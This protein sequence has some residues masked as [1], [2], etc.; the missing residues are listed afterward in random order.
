MKTK[1]SII[2]LTLI[3]FGQVNAQQIIKTESPQ[4]TVAAIS[5]LPA[6]PDASK[7]T[8]TK[9]TSPP[10][11]NKQTNTY[12]RPDANQRFKRYVKHMFGPVS[13][14][15]KVLSAG[16]STATN[17][18]EEWGGTWEGF[19]KRFASSVGRGIIRE[20][21]IYTLGEAFKLDSNFYRS[22]KRDFKSKVSNAVLSTF[23][24]R[25]PDGTRVFGFPHLVGVYASSIIAYETWYPDRYTYKSGLRSGTISLGINVAV[26]LFK[27]FIKK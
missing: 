18:P 3:I 5:D 27:E 17:S 12:V 11:N 19:G 7:E 1:L 4:P 15:T 8:Q 23:T 6:E 26:N 9:P 14:G 16:Y 2:V 10:T 22:Q 25:K 21:T 13:M 20:T 24:A